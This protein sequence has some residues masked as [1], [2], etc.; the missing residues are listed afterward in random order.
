MNEG[1]TPLAALIAPMSYTWQRRLENYQSLVLGDHRKNAGQTEYQYFTEENSSMSTIF[2]WNRSWEG[3]D[4]EKS[5]NEK[6]KIN[7]KRP[8]NADWDSYE[9]IE[10]DESLM[11]SW[12]S[13]LEKGQI[14]IE[15]EINGNKP[16]LADLITLLKK[17]QTIPHPEEVFGK[18]DSMPKKISQ[19]LNAILDLVE[20]G[21]EILAHLTDLFFDSGDEGLE[22]KSLRKTFELK[23]AILKVQLVETDVARDVLY[24]AMAWDSKLADVTENGDDDDNVSS[25][26]L[27]LPTQSLAS[28]ENMAEEGRALSIRPTNLVLLEERIHKAYDLRNRIR[29]WSKVRQ[30]LHILF[31]G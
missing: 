24:E 7:R 1:S 12:T 10:R 14:I 21:R 5:T 26:D 19:C 18:R 3:I 6:S 29:L 4:S 8:I 17:A 28:A 11:A 22:L 27:H 20:N 9:K 25:E 30:F 16:L 13:I 2:P 23:I 31:C 15:N